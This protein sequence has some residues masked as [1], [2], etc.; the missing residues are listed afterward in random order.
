MKLWQPTSY[1]QKS[2]ICPLQL[3]PFC[4]GG[5]QSAHV[6]TQRQWP[7]AHVHFVPHPELHPSQ[8]RPST[9]HDEPPGGGAA[10]HASDASTQCSLAQT[11]WSFVH[12]QVPHS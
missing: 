9:E 8:T 10:G 1:L 5:G 6:S 4:G 7:D 12:W 3:A 11:Q 2:P